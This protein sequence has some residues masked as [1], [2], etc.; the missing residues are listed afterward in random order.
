[1]EVSTRDRDVLRRLAEQQAWI[2]DLPIQKDKADMW[3]RLNQLNSA[4]P[5]VWINDICWHEMN[6]NDE[7]T[8]QCD[9]L[10][11]RSIEQEFRR[12]LYQWRHL[13]GDMVVSNY[14]P[15][16]AHIANTGFGLSEDVDIVRTDQASDIVSRHF[17]R[18]ISKPEDIDKIQDPIITFDE[19]ATEKEAQL[20][21]SIFGDILPVKQMGIRH[22]PFEPWDELVRWWGIEGAMVDLVE[23]PDMVNTII[24]RLIDAYLCELDQYID[25][26]LLS[27]NA[28]NIRI[29]SGGY[30]YTDELPGD[31]AYV[32]LVRPEDM[33]GSATAQIFAVVS[34]EMH[35]EFA[36]RHE[37]RWLKRWGLTYY[38]CCEPLEGKMQIL[39]RIPNLRKVS[40]SPTV[41][42][43]KAVEQVGVDYV[44]SRKP[45][46]AVLAWDHWSPEQ[47]RQELADFLEIGKDCHIEMI[48]KDISTV[49]YQPERL[50]QWEKTA[51]ELVER[52]AK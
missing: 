51:M 33:W 45:N 30:G 48:M 39:R 34:P 7:L 29:G 15:C 40:M 19:D 24:A 31:S 8:L 42:I 37:M 32:Q 22:I 2:A 25:L 17:R 13:P 41:N 11:A 3:R 12:L 6:V 27:V 21:N 49:R 43:E 46:P 23:R 52:Y 50:W 38:G 47:A 1:M 5:M 16:P 4:R 20:L 10:W 28:G 18:Q 36:I 44:F 35:W 26:N 9:N 14:Y